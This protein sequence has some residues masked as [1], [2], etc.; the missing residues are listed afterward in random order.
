M[1]GGF[2][3]A[4]QYSSEILYCCAAGESNCCELAL[5]KKWKLAHSILTLPHS[6]SYRVSKMHSANYNDDLYHLF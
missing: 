5:K 6:L 2:E 4:A 3:H 1:S